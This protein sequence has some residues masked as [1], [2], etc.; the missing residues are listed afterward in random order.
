MDGQL[1]GFDIDLIKEVASVLGYPE[2]QIEFVVVDEFSSLLPGLG[3]GEYDIAMSGVPLTPYRAEQFIYTDPYVSYFTTYE[4]E[5]GEMIEGWEEYVIFGYEN[6]SLIQIINEVIQKLNEEGVI[7]KLAD[8][9]LVQEEAI[10]VEQ[11]M[12]A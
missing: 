5:N 1:V 2:D 7:D 10:S 9:W 8:T 6:D 3:R 12:A 4:D 11:V